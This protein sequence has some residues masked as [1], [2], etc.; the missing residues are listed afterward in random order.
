VG[1]LSF[2]PSRVGNVSILLGVEGNGDDLFTL[3]GVDGKGNGG[4]ENDEEGNG[5]KV[6]GLVKTGDDLFTLFGVDGKVNLL[7]EPNEDKLFT[8]FGVDGKD[9]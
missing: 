5:G 9:N 6:D 1:Y 7:G 3:F 4:K 2:V 8:L